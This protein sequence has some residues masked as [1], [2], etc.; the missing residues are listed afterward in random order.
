[1][2]PNT[3]IRFLKKST[4]KK[5]IASQIKSES[6][7]YLH[8]PTEKGIFPLAFYIR[9][10]TGSLRWTGAGQRVLK[11]DRHQCDDRVSDL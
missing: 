4:K 11:S 1:M 5:P 2:G 8:E 10:K 6:V 9:L 3:K 7:A